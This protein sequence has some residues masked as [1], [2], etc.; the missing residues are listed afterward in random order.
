MRTGFADL[1]VAAEFTFAGDPG[2]PDTPGRRPVHVEQAV[3]V[4]VPPPNPAGSAAVSDLP[5]LTET[6]GWGPVERDQ[7]NG[8]SGGGDGRPLTI[9]GWCTRR[10]WACTRSAR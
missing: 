3:R 7:S 2:S 4:L 8:E 5:F 1:P 10:A 9:R 6:N